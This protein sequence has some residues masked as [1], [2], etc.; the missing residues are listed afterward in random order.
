MMGLTPVRCSA[1]KTT[2]R[3]CS[4]T[5][6][7]LSRAWAMGLRTKAT[8]RV[9]AMRISPTYCPR[10]RR[11]RSSSLRGGEAPIP[12]LAIAHCQLKRRTVKCDYFQADGTIQKLCA[13][14][15]SL[16]NGAAQC[17]SD[18]AIATHPACAGCFDGAKDRRAEGK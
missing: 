2:F 12:Y 9:P 14:R 10:P 16:S 1:V 11:N 6:I 5:L 13:A 8:S 3:N 7:R 15:V 18:A 4:G 17:D